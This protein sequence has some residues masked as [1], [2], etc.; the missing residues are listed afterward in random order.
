VNEIKQTDQDIREYISEQLSELLEN[1]N[2]D[3]AVQGSTKS[4][5]ERENLIF[6]RIEEVIGNN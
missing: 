6:Q 2:F 4:D 3:Y 1:P 5:K